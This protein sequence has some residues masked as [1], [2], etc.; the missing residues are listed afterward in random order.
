MR[1]VT[2]RPSSPQYQIVKGCTSNTVMEFAFAIRLQR[3]SK[4]GTENEFMK[5]E[6]AALGFCIYGLFVWTL[7]QHLNLLFKCSL[8]SQFL[9]LLWKGLSAPLG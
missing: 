4:P 5:K 6:A 3:Y 8:F 1:I 7:Y 2:G 9:W